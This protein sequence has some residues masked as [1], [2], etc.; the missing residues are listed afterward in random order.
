MKRASADTTR[1]LEA[2]D[3]QKAVDT[4]KGPL[5]QYPGNREWTG[6]VAAALDGIDEIAENALQR[7]NYAQAERIFRV[8]LDSY[9]DFERADVPFAFRRSDLENGL[10][11]SRVGII[12]NDAGKAFMSG[13]PARALDI[14]AAGLK[15]FPGDKDLP[16]NCLR[17]AREIKAAGDKALA[18][19]N[20]A[21]AG[22]L[23]SILLQR[24]PIFEG[25]KPGLSFGKPDLEKTIVLC[26][27]ELTKAGLA[28]YRRGTTPKSRRPSIPPRL[29]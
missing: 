14:Y 3:I 13:D 22:K 6:E 20:F 27:D 5:R 7:Q 8:L 10:R 26:R 24:F 2:G 19:E 12:F 15:E 28:E 29:N 18:A 21:Q 25:M 11:N 17:V 1:F 16:A 9:A 4:L 23:A